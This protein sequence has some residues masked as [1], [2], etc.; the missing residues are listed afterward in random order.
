MASCPGRPFPKTSALEISE[1][2]IG[3]SA[4]TNTAS[5]TVSPQLLNM[6]STRILSVAEGL[7]SEPS[8]TAKKTC[9]ERR[10]DRGDEHPCYVDVQVA[11]RHD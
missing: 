2:T 9:P 10:G 6:R 7:R 4:S 8:T 3:R 5:R 11:K 1:K